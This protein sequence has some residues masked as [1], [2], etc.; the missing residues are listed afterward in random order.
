MRRIPA[1]IFISVLTAIILSGCSGSR[2]FAT[3]TETVRYGAP[4]SISE[5]VPVRVLLGEKE[6]DYSF[7]VRETVK[8]FRNNEELALVRRGNKL[9]F[10]TLGNNVKLTIGPKSFDANFFLIKPEKNGGT[11]AYGGRSYRGALK[12]L[13]GNN[14]LK[15]INSLTLDEYLKGVL[16]AEMPSG[17]ESYFQALKAMAICART[18][19]LNRLAEKKSIFDVY[20]DTRD[21]AYSGAS[22]EHRLTDKAVDETSGQALYYN[23]R[24]AEVYYSAA[25]GG[26]TADAAN[27]FGTQDAPY[28]RGV[29]DGD[30]PNCSIEPGFRWEEI[31]PE[32]VFISRLRTA[33][34]VKHK[35]YS[36]RDVE[37]ES[38]TSSGRVADLHVIL[39]NKDDGEITV[40][41]PGVRLRNILRTADNTSILRSTLF[42]VE[43][44]SGD[45][46]KLIGRGNG[47]GVGLCQWGAIAQS[48]RGKNYRQILNFYFPGTE[49][50]ELR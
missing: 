45:E 5:N 9:N 7:E 19:T 17:S 10:T 18:Y 38:R 34:L 37:V 15:I 4:A 36:L 16:P 6:N 40:D 33:G 28:L 13:P 20:L 12:I 35:E 21:Q 2:R 26:H 42:K 49:I 50:K 29:E 22:G 32:E 27:V 25:C 47:H 1:I 14:S 48:K 11:L 23:G 31:Y 24:P 41:I 3:K 43:M 30:P 8:I 39:F 44:G 46:V